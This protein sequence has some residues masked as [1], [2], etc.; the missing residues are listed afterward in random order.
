MEKVYI[1]IDNGTTASIGVLHLGVARFLKP[2]TRS[3]LNYHKKAANITRIDHPAFLVMMRGLR[4]EATAQGSDL[5]A[6]MEKPF[7]GMAHTAALS[8]RCYESEIIALE[9]L[10]I[11]Y[12]T[13]CS[14]DWQGTQKAAG[15]LPTGLKGSKAQKVASLDVGCRL[16]PHLADQIRKH[17]D[18]DGLLIAKWASRHGL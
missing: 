2:P 6:I 11:P 15:M 13:I 8:A 7:T 14:T 16:F 1:G 9:A 3:V 18:A 10:G 5:V 12:E 4:D 17:K